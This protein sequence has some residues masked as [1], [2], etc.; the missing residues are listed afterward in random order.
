MFI[1]SPLLLHN[2]VLVHII[3]YCNDRV[4]SKFGSAKFSKP[5]AILFIQKIMRLEKLE[6]VVH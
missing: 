2:T 5:C 6:T 1:L 4:L 3:L